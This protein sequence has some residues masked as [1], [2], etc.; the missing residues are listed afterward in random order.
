ME[1]GWG[2]MLNAD[3]RLLGCQISRTPSF[4]LSGVSIWT[5]S[6]SV[7]LANLLVEV[8]NE[9]RLAIHCLIF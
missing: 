1:P 2:E 5:A 3:F 4:M 6:A 9:D 7:P 8:D